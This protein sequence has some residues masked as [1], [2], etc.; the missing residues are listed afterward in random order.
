MTGVLVFI[1]VW[2][3]LAVVGVAFLLYE[4]HRADRLEQRYP[5]TDPDMEDGGEWIVDEHGM[6]RKR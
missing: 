3:A 5:P 2:I 1:L 4:A 6:R